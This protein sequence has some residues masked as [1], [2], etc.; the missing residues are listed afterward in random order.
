LGLAVIKLLPWLISSERNVLI[1]GRLARDSAL[2]Y[3]LG[4]E[5]G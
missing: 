2:K 3:R 1:S 4:A 5:I